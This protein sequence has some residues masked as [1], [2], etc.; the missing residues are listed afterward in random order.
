MDDINFRWLITYNHNGNDNKPTLQYY[1]EYV[2][3]WED[4]P[5][6][7]CREDDEVLFSKPERKI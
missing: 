3:G 4:I 2:E 5:I 6:V 1:D 7:R